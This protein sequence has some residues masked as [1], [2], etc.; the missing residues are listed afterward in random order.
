M[1]LSRDVTTEQKNVGLVTDQMQKTKLTE[2]A[3]ATAPVSVTEKDAI[4]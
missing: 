4:V 3:A 2:S 1:H